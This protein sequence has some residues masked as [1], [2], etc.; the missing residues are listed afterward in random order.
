MGGATV[1][2]LRDARKRYGNVEA[3]RGVDLVIGRGEIVAMLGPNGA[4]GLMLGLRRPPRD[5]P[6]SSD[7][8]PLIDRRAVGAA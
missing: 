2:E 4:G 5:A 6:G 8:T 3:L 7:S 1:V